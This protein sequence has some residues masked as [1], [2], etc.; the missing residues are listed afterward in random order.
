MSYIINAVYPTGNLLLD[1][2]FSELTIYKS[3]LLKCSDKHTPDYMEQEDVEF[4]LA[5]Q[6]YD[7]GKEVAREGTDE[8]AENSVYRDPIMQVLNTCGI[9]YV[10]IYEKLHA[11]K[12]LNDKMRDFVG[13]SS[14]IPETNTVYKSYV[15]QYA[16]HAIIEKAFLTE[17]PSCFHRLC[18]G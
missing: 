6:L 16:L 9:N 3:F 15:I 8:Y 18:S 14:K 11:S 4:Y 12:R 13:G 5:E 1:V 10:E 2:I 7:L 17:N